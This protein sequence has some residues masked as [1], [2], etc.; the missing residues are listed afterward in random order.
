MDA[1]NGDQT[2]I[3]KKPV[4]KYGANCYRKNKDHLD[5]YKH[6]SKRLQHDA[7]S[8]DPKRVCHGDSPKEADLV[9]GAAS[10]I[11]DPA[12]A[13]AASSHNMSPEP[14][15][16]PASD[17]ENARGEEADESRPLEEEQNQTA[18][19]EDELAILPDSPL[20]DK[21]NIKQKFLVDMPKDFYSFLKFCKS[22]NKDAPQDALSACGLRL[23]GPFLLLLGRIKPK[24]RTQ[25]FYLTYCR[26]YYDPPEVQTVL[27]GDDAS[28][29]HIGYFR[30]QPSELPV[31]VVANSAEKNGT[32]SVLG[33]NLFAAVHKLVST[34]L[35][36]AEG[37][38]KDAL[39][40]LQKELRSWA[41]RCSFTLDTRTAA[42]KQRDKLVLG[43]TLQG[44]GVVVP[45]DKEHDVGYRNVPETHETLRKMMK[46]VVEAKT[47]EQK[48]AAL[49]KLQE[50]IQDVQFANDE[51]DPG[52]G[53]EFG[54]DVFGYGGEALYNTVRHVLLLAYDL[55]NRPVSAQILR[56][57][58]AN[59]RKG[60][61]EL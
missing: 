6:P 50:V 19:E 3:D 16:V 49:D 42:M 27:C 11:T 29:Y 61:P 34:Q 47:D 55:L 13:P 21:D 37:A 25:E 32:F 17:T 31:Q 28:G 53:L 33:D 54:L 26:Y 44:L 30:D 24:K 9:A 8:P 39:S 22:L 52:M 10:S 38:E 1:G 56:A 60:P 51:G 20:S 18:E 59:R 57:H 23:A 45:Y 12:P 4:C 14:E 2:N 35:S 58:L 41:G 36:S 48:D 40:H 15:A 46:R 5:K 43:K 7:S